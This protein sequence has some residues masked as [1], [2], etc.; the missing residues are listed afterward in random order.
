M[1]FWLWKKEIE[2]ICISSEIDVS[3]SLWQNLLLLI[4]GKYIDS[5]YDYLAG[6]RLVKDTGGNK[7]VALSYAKT[8]IPDRY[9]A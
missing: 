1:L 6:S 9:S 4:H 8:D 3:S 2:N 7:F 5:V